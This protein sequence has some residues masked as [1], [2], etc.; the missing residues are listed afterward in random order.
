MGKLALVVRDDRVHT[1]EEAGQVREGDHV[2]FLAPPDRVPALDRFFAERPS[3]ASPDAALVEDFFV[4]GDVTMGALAE[5]YGLTIPAEDAGTLLADY[6]AAYFIKHPPRPLD[7]IPLGPVK[8]VAHTVNRR[9]CRH[10]RSSTRRAR[11]GAANDLG[12]SLDQ[13]PPRH[14]PAAGAAAP[15]GLLGGEGGGPRRPALHQP[16]AAPNSAVA[17]NRSPATVY[18]RNG[19]PAA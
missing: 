4:P 7:A 14:A 13:G 19:R 17:Q 1:P 12:K 2:Y 11:T 16:G 15:R 5:I 10:G 18:F 9:P 6:F 8:L 3:Q